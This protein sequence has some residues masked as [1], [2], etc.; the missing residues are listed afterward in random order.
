MSKNTVSIYYDQLCIF[1]TT[2]FAYCITF[3]KTR[4]E[5]NKNICFVPKSISTIDEKNNIIEVPED[6]ALK[7][8][9]DLDNLIND[10]KGGKY[11]H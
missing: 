6:F 11:D 4:S 3:G 7:K 5:R 9:E 10:I 8:F 1:R 2:K